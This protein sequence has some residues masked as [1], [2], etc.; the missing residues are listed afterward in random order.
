MARGVTLGL[1]STVILS[2]KDNI[3]PVAQVADYFAR[4]GK[5]SK[6]VRLPDARH[7]ARARC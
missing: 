4:H 5:Q 2:E 7:A 6:L 1:A 3:V